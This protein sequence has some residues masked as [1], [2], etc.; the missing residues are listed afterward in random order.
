MSLR[1]HNTI[2]ST[3]HFIK[4]KEIKDTLAPAELLLND[5]HDIIPEHQGDVPGNEHARYEEE[6]LD[7]YIQQMLHTMLRMPSKNFRKPN[8]KIT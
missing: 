5:E 2:I 8:G 1:D 7:N 4:N 6:F 3:F